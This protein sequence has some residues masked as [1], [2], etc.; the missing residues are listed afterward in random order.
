[1]LGIFLPV[2]T[3]AAPAELHY[4]YIEHVFSIKPQKSWQVE[5]EVP[6]YHGRELALKEGAKIPQGVV[7][8]KKIIWNRKQIKETI[9]KI[10]GSVINREQGHVR[11][12]RNEEGEIAFEGVG[13]TGRELRSDETVDLTLK[14]LEENISL[15]QLPIVEIDP[16]VIVEDEELKAQGIIELVTIGESDYAGS[17]VNRRHNIGVGLTR[18]NGALIP[19]GEEFSFN[20]ILGPVNGYTGYRPELTIMGEKTL[21]EF[22][23]GLCQVSTTAY[24]G[25]WLA[26]FPITSRRNH[27]YAVRYYAPAG[28]DAT[29]Y[30]PTTDM[31]FM[32]DTNGALLIQ[33][34]AENERAYF[35]YYGTKPKERSVELVGPFTWDPVGPPPDRMEYTSEIPPG[36]VR[37]VSKPV[38]GMKAMWYRY[39]STGD[40]ETVPEEYLS[41]YEARPYFEEIGSV[42][43]PPSIIQTPTRDVLKIGEDTT[44]TIPKRNDPGP[45]I[46]IRR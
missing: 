30:P 43:T 34:H 12:F 35:V 32:N 24:R 5:V 9:E 23:G 26:G 22:G 25:V 17:P 42:L 44:I 21:P 13:L 39:I 41:I 10:I 36:E 37:V 4:Q 29:I 45:R 31:R 14:A 16:E 19:K 8:E 3:L 38:S 6:T 11:I 2:H 18:F 1:M 7:M 33:T 46:R 15:I 28:T 20:K 27:S 40:T